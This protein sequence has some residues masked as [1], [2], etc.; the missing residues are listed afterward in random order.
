LIGTKALAARVDRA[1][2]C[3]A[4]T[5]LPVPVS[6]RMSTGSAVGAKTSSSALAFRRIGVGMGLVVFG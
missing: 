6:P 3:F 2:T 4:K 5:S 1:W